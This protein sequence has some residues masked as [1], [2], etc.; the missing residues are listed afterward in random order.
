M[1]PR[2]AW[3]WVSAFAVGLLAAA[4]TA[5]PL[6]PR[7]WSA[8]TLRVDDRV[9]LAGELEPAAVETL[10]AL[11]AL[12]VDLRAADEDGVAESRARFAG[13]AV[14]LVPL[15]LDREAPNRAVVR[16]FAELLDSA[17]KPVVVH[18]RSGNRAG[19][20][21]AIHLLEQGVPPEDAL[22]AVDGIVTS[23]AIRESIANYAVRHETR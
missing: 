1:M 17:V 10:D 16:Q 3:R 6:E 21:W 20:L 22:S 14:R 9:T 7:L 18:C 23:D 11:G 19:L 2:S 4:G 12:V 5:D 13:T 15:A 8:E